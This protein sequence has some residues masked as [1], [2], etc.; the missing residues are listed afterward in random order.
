MGKDK[1]LK[2]LISV[3]VCVFFAVP[4]LGATE[5]IYPLLNLPFGQTLILTSDSTLVDFTIYFY[6]LFVGIGTV[7]LFAVVVWSGLGMIISSGNP[8]KFQSA[9]NRILGAGIGLIVLFLSYLILNAISPSLI[10]PKNI[11]IT[12]DT[13]EVP[14][15][16]ER[17]VKTEGEKDRT[18]IEM[19][20]DTSPDLGLKTGEMIAIKRYNG[21]KEIWGYSGTNWTG[22][23][24]LLYKDN[25]PA[26]KEELDN[27]LPHAILIDSA[28]QS[29]KVFLKASGF[30]LYESENSA[31]QYLNR[32]DSELNFSGSVEIIN[33]QKENIKYYGVGFGKSGYNDYGVANSISAPFSCLI[34]DQ[35]GAVPS[36]SSL[37]LFQNNYFPSSDSAGEVVFYNTIKCGV[38]KFEVKNCPVPFL[39]QF[40]N[41]IKSINEVCPEWQGEKILS[42]RITGSAGVVL[43]GGSNICKYWDNNVVDESGN[44]IGYDN[45][46]VTQFPQNFLIIP[47]SKKL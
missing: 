33:K 44:C 17:V 45:F 46:L 7:V 22:T 10:K 18:L 42:F 36:I 26:T 41:Q 23:A 37:M 21:L 34:I 2:I 15:C 40:S 3:I 47:F 4:V 35:D 38:G 20:F 11:E 12:C 16:V 6:A 5:T 19:S 14:V 9:K 25:N 8:A 1:I 27:P 30:Y 43:F 13:A 39:K 32:S 29:V 28:I 31:P 24:A